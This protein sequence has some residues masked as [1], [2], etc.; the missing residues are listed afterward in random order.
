MV[1]WKSLL[2]PWRQKSDLACCRQSIHQNLFHC[3]VQKSASQWVRAI[4][5]DARTFQ[6]CGLRSYQY[7]DQLPGKYDPR[8]LT[9]RRF[10]EA[11]P[12]STIATPIYI[13]YDGFASIPK[14]THYKAFFV[15][16]DPRE[17]VVSWYYSGK[18]S[19]PL[20]GDLETMRRDLVRLSEQDGL[21]LAID[22]LHAFGLFAA[23]RSWADAPTKD[24]NVLPVRY[25]DLIA[26]DPLPAFERLFA[27]CD[28]AMPRNVLGELLRTYSF[29]QLSGH[30]AGDEDLKA[31]YRKGVSGDW[32]THFDEKVKAHFTSVA[33][34]LIGLWNYDS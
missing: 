12:T 6:F 14:P 24:A 34:D 33:G 28:I 32:R 30:K 7:Q 16:R 31:H 19:H 27:H 17:V 18:F 15:M 9:E 3:T 11:F 25:E 29:E 8:R 20:V 13:D 4:L 10:T 21:L 1:S 22:H 23:Q 5:S 2:S 26:A